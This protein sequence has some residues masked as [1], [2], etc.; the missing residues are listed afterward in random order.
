MTRYKTQV[1]DKLRELALRV[2]GLENDWSAKATKS[3][4]HMGYAPMDAYMEW[5]GA[6]KRWEG[7]LKRV[8]A[9]EKQVAELRTQLL[10][11]HEAV[12]VNDATAH[13]GTRIL[14]KLDIYRGKTPQGRVIHPVRSPTSQVT[15][16]HVAGKGYT[17][18]ELT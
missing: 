6:L 14:T 11:H 17:D 10:N 8:Q 1:G 9:L 13:N 15:E 18:K 12:V 3:H 7:A 5:E 2:R 4:V 16:Y